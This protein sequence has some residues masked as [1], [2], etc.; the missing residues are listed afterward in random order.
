[1]V[2][3]RKGQGSLE[4]MMTYGWVILIVLIALVVM[5]QLGL[6]NISSRIEPGTF[7]FW[8]VIVHDNKLDNAGFFKVTLLNNVGGNVTLLEY[9]VTIDRT[10]ILMPC[11]GGCVLEPGKTKNIDL[12]Q[13]AKWTSPAGQRYDADMAITYRD[14]RT[15]AN[16][17]Q[18]SGKIWGSTEG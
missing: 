15:G 14:A 13:E 10:S 11:S 8:G 9:N 2:P 1:M 7:G 3:M 4:F 6:F 5:W 17:M 12:P 18:S 16:I